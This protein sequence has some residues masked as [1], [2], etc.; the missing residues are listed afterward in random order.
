MCTS[1]QKTQILA[2]RKLADMGW[3]GTED[4]AKRL[5]DS[6]DEYLQRIAWEGLYAID[7]PNYEKLLNQALSSTNELLVVKA[8]CWKLNEEYMKEAR[9]PY[10][11]VCHRCKSWPSQTE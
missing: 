1:C 10:T 3:E 11:C 4:H 5:W 6:G 2:F 8:E 7:S 9:R